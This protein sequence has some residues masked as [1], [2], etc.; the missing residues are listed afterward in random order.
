MSYVLEAE[1]FSTLSEVVLGE[2][3]R[4]S[5]T[6]G[7]K[8]SVA[9]HICE[10]CI[11]DISMFRWREEGG[12]REEEGEKQREN[13]REKEREQ[14]RKRERER[15]REREREHA[16][17]KGRARELE[18]ERERRKQWRATEKSERV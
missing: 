13:G 11:E 18:R 16:R 12:D 15:N 17:A 6:R 2:G 10:G 1:T 5:E 9:V 7:R 4:D 8:G 3:Q 14:E